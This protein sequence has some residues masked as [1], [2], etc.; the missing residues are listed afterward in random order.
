MAG[1]DG[2]KLPAYQ[3]DRDG[4]GLI[5]EWLNHDGMGDRNNNGIACDNSS[6]PDGYVPTT[7]ESESELEP[8][9]VFP[10]LDN[11]FDRLIKLIKN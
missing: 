2:L 7:S 11:W 9:S 3:D 5:Y 1:P 8:V 4:T 6:N 10:F